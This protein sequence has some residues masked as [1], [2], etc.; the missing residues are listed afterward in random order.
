MTLL[1]VFTALAGAFLVSAVLTPAARR[2]ALKLNF[3]DRPGKEQKGHLK[4]TPLLGGVALFL[5][6]TAVMVVGRIAWPNLTE[7]VVSDTP[8]D[9]NSLSAMMIIAATLILMAGLLDDIVGMKPVVKLLFHTVVALLVGL[10]FVAN[11]ASLRLFLDRFSFS[12]LTAPVTLLW[13]VGIT[14]SVNLLDHSDGVCAGISAIAAL[15][16][17]V[18]NVLHGN[19]A[20]AFPAAGLAGAALGFLL[21][22]FPPAGIFMGDGGSN[23][24]GFL[25]AIIAVLGVYTPE[26]SIRELAVLTP[27]LILAVPITDTLLVMLYRKNKHVPLMKGDRNHL[28]H[29]L[30][31]LGFTLRESVCLLYLLGILMG[32]LALLLPT[33]RPYQ[34]VLLFFHALGL[35]ALLAFLLQKSESVRGGG[36]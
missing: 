21:Y 13:L 2:V 27:L 24:L 36:A 22:N 26:G 3:V 34:A 16:F 17:T 31:R 11:G 20:V 1:P 9:W 14:N 25:L 35:V 10:Y 32:I 29:R 23:L 7:G 33:L 15:F 4:P 18:V 6:F 30:T 5:A 19:M 8:L 28:T 12:L